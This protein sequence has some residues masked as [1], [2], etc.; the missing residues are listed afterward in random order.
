MAVPMCKLT[1]GVS[2]LMTYTFTY[3]HS[4]G[5]LLSSSG[6]SK[7]RATRCP[8]A[9]ASIVSFT[10]QLEFIYHSPGALLSSSGASKPRAMR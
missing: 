10:Q 7:P 5:A 9:H 1:P 8:M 6:A 3:H 2:R 4:P